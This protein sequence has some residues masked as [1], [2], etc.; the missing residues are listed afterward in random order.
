MMAIFLNTLIIDI[1]KILGAS[2]STVYRVLCDHPDIK[3]ETKEQIKKIAKEFRYYPIP[4]AQSLKSN[5]PISIGV[6]V[7]EIKRDFFS[8]TM[9]G[10]QCYI[11]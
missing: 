11:S 1:A 10:I 8:S 3:N 2:T 5:P 7:P 9:S 6:I 4:I